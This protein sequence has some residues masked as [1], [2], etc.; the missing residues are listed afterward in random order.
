MVSMLNWLKS[1]RYLF[2]NLY[3]VE[4]ISNLKTLKPLD[5]SYTNKTKIIKAKMDCILEAVRS[6]HV[7]RQMSDPMYAVVSCQEGSNQRL[8]RLNPDLC[9]WLRGRVSWWGPLW[10][11]SPRLGAC[12]WSSPMGRGSSLLDL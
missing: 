12:W 6:K 5:L 9:V 8:V 4:R 7:S 11:C 3:F 10:G 1:N 2:I